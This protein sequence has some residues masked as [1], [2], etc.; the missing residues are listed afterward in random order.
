MSKNIN[1]G[2]V[3]ATGVVGSTFLDLMKERQFSVQ[4]LKLFAS[5]QSAGKKIKFNNKEIIVESLKPG[6]FEGLH[7][8]FFSS[9]D[10]I[11]KEWAP[12]AIKSGAYAIDNSAAFRMD[13][14][15]PLVVPEV[16]GHLLAKMNQPQIIANPNCS[17]IQLVVLL[18]PLAERFSLKS[19]KVSSYQAVSG[20]GAPAIT[21]LLNQN[22]TLQYLYDLEAPYD[23]VKSF[24]QVHLKTQPQYLPKEIAY[25]CVPQIGGWVEDGSTSEER[26]IRLETKKILDLPNLPVSAFTV[27]VP[28]I[29]AHCETVWVEFDKKIPKEELFNSLEG[30]KGLVIYKDEKQY[31]LASDA[32]G[33]DP[34]FVGRIH[35]DAD[36]PETWMFWV[37]SDNLKK[38]AALNGI[39]IA[40]A[41]L[42]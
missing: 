25:N 34:V 10:D 29:N 16:N 24:S 12:Q 17:T 5:D 4:N 39:Q 36:Q 40:E 22:R 9:G 20:A 14:S 27:R 7:V 2:I 42:I 37:V 18:K 23:V 28:A 31:A 3:G 26:K 30:A 6:C 21:E 11:S 38:G 8:V 32:S 33:K 41:L 15:I 1:L 35:Q 13:Q 19:V